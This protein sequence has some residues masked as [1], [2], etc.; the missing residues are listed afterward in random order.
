MRKIKIIFIVLLI[1]FSMDPAFGQS[2]HFDRLNFLVGEWEGTGRGFG[3][4]SS[5]VESSFKL[6]MDGKYIEVK[7]ESE[8][9]PTE[10]N[11]EG[12]HHIDR[13][14]ISYDKGR[15]A[16]VLRQF[17]N[18]GYVTQYTLNDSLSNDSLL[19]FETEIIENFIPGGKA[20]WTIRKISESRIETIFDLSFPEKD[21]TCMGTNILFRK[22]NGSSD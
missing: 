13:G 17:H 10:K 9:E 7:N 12:E 3:N 14:F 5:V 21:Y 19:V 16:T 15:N 1:L 18:E 4:E 22:D 6:V 2:G 8:F 20:R 11:P